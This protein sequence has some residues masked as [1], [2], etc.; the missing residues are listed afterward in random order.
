MQVFLKHVSEIPA[1]R[2]PVWMGSYVSTCR[3]TD[4]TCLKIE[5]SQYGRFFYEEREKRYY[6]LDEEM[7]DHWQSY[8]N[9]KWSQLEGTN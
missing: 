5:I 1:K 9:A 8:L 7:Q 2:I 4:G 6:Q 3:L